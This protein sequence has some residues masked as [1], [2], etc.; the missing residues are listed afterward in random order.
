MLRRT[1]T[2]PMPSQ[3]IL[4]PEQKIALIE[5]KVARAEAHIRS[6][7]EMAKLLNKQKQ[8]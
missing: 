8:R 2:E 4:T 6:M 7:A 5:A 1:N 3:F